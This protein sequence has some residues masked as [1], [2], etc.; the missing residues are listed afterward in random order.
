MMIVFFGLIGY[1]GYSLFTGFSFSLLGTW[2]AIWFAALL[3]IG[4]LLPDWSLLEDVEKVY[5][6]L[7]DAL[8]QP[9]R[10]VY[11]D[12]LDATLRRMFKVRDQVKKAQALL[13]EFPLE[14]LQNQVK[15][16]A[17]ELT[18]LSPNAENHSRVS[19]RLCDLQQTLVRISAQE[20]LSNDFTEMKKAWIA[21]LGHLKVRLE[22]SS[23]G[24]TPDGNTD[25]DEVQQELSS[26][27]RITA[28][29]EEGQPLSSRSGQ[30][31]PA[32]STETEKR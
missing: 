10:K 16:T 4:F 7:E 2:L 23:D 17:A 31:S 6:S 13:K 9:G 28:A 1:G 27:L 21:S 25:G 32:A 26:L 18:L 5:K 20:Q 11:R 15:E 8:D 12:E 22:T 19:D 24:V 14:K 3:V 29:V 30:S